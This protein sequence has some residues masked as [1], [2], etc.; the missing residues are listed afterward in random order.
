[1]I[2]THEDV[3]PGMEEPREAPSEDELRID[4]D[5]VDGLQVFL[6]DIG[7]CPC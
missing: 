3:L 7:G 6:R 2:E 5:T 1:M 4:P